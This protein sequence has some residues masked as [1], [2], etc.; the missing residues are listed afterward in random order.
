MDCKDW[1][2][3]IFNEHNIVNCSTIR[4]RALKKGFSKIEIQVA[5]HELGVTTI[6]DASLQKDG[7]AKNWF[8]LIPKGD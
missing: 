5:K 7:K 2:T 1:L 4:K 6:N 3:E 8:W